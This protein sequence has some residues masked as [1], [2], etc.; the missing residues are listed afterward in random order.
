MTLL[1]NRH[2]PLDKESDKIERPFENRHGIVA[3]K[4][5]KEVA[6]RNPMRELLGLELTAPPGLDTD[7]LGTFSGEIPRKSSIEATVLQKARWGLEHTEASIGLA[8]EGSFR[9]NPLVPFVNEHTEVIAF[10]DR[11]QGIEIVE[12][13]RA[14]KQV[15]GSKVVDLETDIE[16]FLEEVQ[17]P[18]HGLI[19]KPNQVS[20]LKKWFSNHAIAKGIQDPEKL[21][22]AIQKAAEVSKDQKVVIESD[23]RAFMNPTRMQTI[24][25]LGERLAQRLM[26]PCPE[27]ESPGWGRTQTVPGLPCEWCG[28]PTKLVK[29]EIYRCSV[30]EY[31]EDHKRSDGKETADPTYCEHCN[32]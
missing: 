24:A 26:T 2:T 25:E 15:C 11:D 32:P 23:V 4:H 19:V 16:A 3:T 17:F 28:L 27:C 31:V 6:L 29:S 18:S 12:W 8:T 20:A 14:E 21:R 1:E 9:A 30:C 7:L 13:I 22:S 5:G 10:I